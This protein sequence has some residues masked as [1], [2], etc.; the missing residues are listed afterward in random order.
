F[1]DPVEG[2]SCW[3]LALSRNPMQP[4]DRNGDL[5]LWTDVQRSDG[6]SQETL[7]VSS[8][9]GSLRTVARQGDPAPAGGTITSI[10]SWPSLVNLRG[11]LGAST[12]GTS[13]GAYTSHMLLGL[14]ASAVT[15]LVAVRG[16][17]PG[18]LTLDWDDVDTLDTGSPGYDVARGGLGDLHQG[19]WA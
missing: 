2:G 12:P 13:D 19:G 8:R 4:L 17:S 9:D 1:F 3:G 18:A 7:V 6:S 15:S 5:L 10:Q 16:P 11:T 14:G